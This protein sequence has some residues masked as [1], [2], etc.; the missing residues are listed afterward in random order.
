MDLAHKQRLHPSTL[1]CVA[2]HRL[3]QGPVVLVAETL[4]AEQEDP[5]M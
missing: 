3:Y 1:K 4:S 2:N 5:L